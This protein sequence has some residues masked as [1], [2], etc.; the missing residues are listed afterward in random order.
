[1]RLDKL[2]EIKRLVIYFFYDADGIVDRYVPYMLEDLKKNCSEIFVVC[3]GKLT[4]EGRDVF[5]EITPNIL[6]RENKGFDV[7]AYKVALEQYG[8]DE[9]EKYDEVILMNFTMYGPLYPFSEMFEEMD[10]RDVDFW[11][12]TKH[13]GFPFDPFGTIP[14]G[15]IPEHIQSSFICIRNAMLSSIEFHKYWNDMPAVNSYGDAVGKHEAIFTHT[16]E[17]Y[18][19]KSDVYVQTDDLKDY[20]HYP[21]ML[22]AKELVANRKC[23]VFKRKSFTNEYY[24]FLNAS[25]GEPTVELYEYIRD[26]LDYDLNMVWENLLRIENMADIKK[27]MHLNYILPRD[28]VLY[29]EQGCKDK[30]ALVMHIYFEDQIEWCIRYAK[31]MPPNADIIITTA[32]E[33]NKAEIEKYAKEFENR[34]TVLKI[35]NRG[36]DVSALLVAAAPYLEKYDLI[37]FAHDKK[38]TQVLPYSVGQSFAYKCFE[39]VLGSKEYVRNIIDTFQREPR[40]GLLMPPPP[41]HGGFYGIFGT[42]W[43]SNFDNT[44][45]LAKKLGIK[46]NMNLMKEPISPLGTIF[47]FRV[48]ALKPIFKKKW[49][50]EDFPAEPNKYDGTLLHAIERLYGFAS[51]SQGYYNV[52]CMHDK[53][54]AIELT[55]YNFMLR[56]MTL[57]TYSL[58]GHQSCFNLANYNLQKLTP[59]KQTRRLKVKNKI[60]KYIPKPIW[61]VVK[62]FYHLFGGKKWL[63]ETLC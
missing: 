13:H 46:A 52:W 28:V 44:V 63:D 55:N 21:L 31:A 61:K 40:L 20:T 62:W 8:W 57:S 22:E 7:W 14:C 10:K 47:W 39:N 16:F 23:P 48:N 1:M 36:R 58:L 19:F 29:P 4:P 35:K 24:E 50:Y 3:N 26:N 51:Q 18:G 9:L 43:A 60:R 15:Y 17:D 49:T 54:A 38:T 34:V 56:E 6:V 12:I 11:G 32:S 27:R 25:V 53:F 42:E 30:I 5:T 59:G 33:K 45:E 2:T 37:C 41:N